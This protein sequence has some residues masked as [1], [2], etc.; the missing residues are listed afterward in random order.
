MR[1]GGTGTEA[2]LLEAHGGRR[3]EPEAECGDAI[4][5][6]RGALGYRH[7]P[8]PEEG[9]GVLPMGLAEGERRKGTVCNG[10]SCP[11]LAGKT[12]LKR[13][14]AI[15]GMRQLSPLKRGL[16]L[17][18]S[19]VAQNMGVYG[20]APS[21][22]HCLWVLVSA[23]SQRSVLFLAGSVFWGRWKRLPQTRLRRAA[24]GPCPCQ[25]AAGLGVSKDHPHPKKDSPGLK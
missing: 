11:E 18:C 10:I 8:V 5:C 1:A 22:S 16:A 3:S 2:P 17:L 12:F 9:R 4:P 19:A 21:L 24:P 20:F 15:D 23:P 25:A 13:K 14:A 7:L 6:P